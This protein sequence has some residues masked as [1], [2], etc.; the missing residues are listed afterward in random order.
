MFP[1]HWLFSP[2]SGQT[3]H[4][5]VSICIVHLNVSINEDTLNIIDGSDKVQTNLV[6][7]QLVR[8]GFIEIS[9]F[10]RSLFWWMQMDHGVMIHTEVFSCLVI[11]LFSYAHMPLHISTAPYAW[12]FSWTSL[13]NL[14]S[15]S[16][17]IIIQ[18]HNL[19]QGLFVQFYHC[20]H[21]NHNS[22]F[23]ALFVHR[24]IW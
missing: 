10:M 13:Q 19:M 8:E 3:N 23:F 1:W 15:N 16:L 9:I 6:C 12:L 2:K 14:N 24:N 20:N 5:S 7:S 11:H 17:G 22:F 21:G 18:S 4:W